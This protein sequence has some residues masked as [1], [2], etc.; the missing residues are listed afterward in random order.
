MT[1]KLAELT[2]AMDAKYHYEPGHFAPGAI[3]SRAKETFKGG[4]KAGQEFSLYPALNAQNKAKLIGEG[5]ARVLFPKDQAT[6][7]GAGL[8]AGSFAA[9]RR[10]GTVGG[11]AFGATLAGVTSASD[12]E[13]VA[14]SVV[15][16][17]VKSGIRR[18]GNAAWRLTAGIHP[19]IP[20]SLSVVQAIF[21]GKVR[22]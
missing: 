4:I 7:I 17:V 10:L 11:I 1:I 16:D 18:T 14:Q 20:A 19:S 6:Q 15:S 3:F 9:V 13:F 22:W 12:V 5:V 21:E 8:G 2:R